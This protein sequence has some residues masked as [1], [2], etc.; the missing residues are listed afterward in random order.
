MKSIGKVEVDVK[1]AARILIV[2]DNA[3]VRMDLRTLLDLIENVEVAGEANN[4]SEAILRAQEIHP[5][6][7]VMDLEMSNQNSSLIN[8]EFEGC[9]AIRLLKK[10]QPGMNIFVLTVHDYRKARLAAIEAGADAFLIKGR[11][12]E[13]LIKKIRNYKRK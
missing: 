5:D 12:T 7:T 10:I 13:T 4:G 6:I 9:L 2:D 3:D 8:A 1:S 11:D